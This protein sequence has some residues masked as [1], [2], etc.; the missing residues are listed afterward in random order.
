MYVCTYV[1]M[2][3]CMYTYIYIYIYTYIHLINYIF[4]CM[5]IGCMCALVCMFLYN[6][7]I[8]MYK[9]SCYQGFYKARYNR[10]W[11]QS[12]FRSLGVYGFGVS[13]Q[14]P[15]LNRKVLLCKAPGCQI[16][17]RVRQRPSGWS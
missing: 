7:Q 13:G 14:V 16:L 10:S 5:H 4:M 3:V 1:C 15:G 11:A 9:V 2:Y 17:M 6:T 12:G 8:G